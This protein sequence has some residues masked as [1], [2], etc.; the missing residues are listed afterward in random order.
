MNTV[1]VTI[2]LTNGE[3][4]KYGNLNEDTFDVSE[5]AAIITFS[6]EEEKA[7]AIPLTS[8]LYIDTNPDSNDDFSTN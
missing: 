7:R 4:L 6:E 8:I 5:Y 1:D 3:I 2:T